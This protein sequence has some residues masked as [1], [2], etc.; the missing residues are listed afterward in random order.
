V[1]RIDTILWKEQSWIQDKHPIMLLKHH[2]R[3]PF[4]N[5]PWKLQHKSFCHRRQIWLDYE[6]QSKNPNSETVVPRIRPGVEYQSY[7]GLSQLYDGYLQA[8]I[9]S[10][11]K[12]YEFCKLTELLKFDSGQNGVIWVIRSLDH[13][14]NGN[15][16]NTENQTRRYLLKFLMHP[17]MTYSGKQNQSYSD[18]KVGSSAE[19]S[20]KK[21]ETD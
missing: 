1:R 18:L 11:V 2:N 19:F 9:S 20:K 7:R 21:L 3:W 4:L 15:H 14:W 17:Y 5:P 6:Q 13:L 8:L 10:A 16:V 12:S